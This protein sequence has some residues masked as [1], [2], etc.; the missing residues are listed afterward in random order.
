MKYK[1]LKSI[2]ASQKDP[3]TLQGSSDSF[4][5]KSTRVAPYIEPDFSKVAFPKEKPSILLVSAVGAS[6]KTTAAHALSFDMQLP[7]LDLAKHKAVGDNTLTGILTTSYPIDK[8]G[9]VLE[10][11]QKGTHGIIIDGIDEGR[12]KTTEQA[13]EAF[14]DDLIQLSKGS[15][16]TAIVVFGRSQILLSTW[17]YLADNGAE[18]GMV[19]IDPFTLEQAKEYI[20]SSVTGASIGQQETYE[21]VRNEVLAKL[22]AAFSP[23]TPKDKKD[24]NVFLS[25]IGYPPVLDAIATLLEKERNYHRIHQTLS[26]G[27]EGGLE[28]GLLIRISDYLLDRE[29]KEKA[30]PNFIEQIA[31]T[32]GG[33]L[34]QN[35]RKSLYSREEQCARVLSRALN[36]PF[37]RRVIND[38]A[39]HEQYENA[40]GEW[41]KEH[42]FLDDKSVRNVVFAAFAVTRCTLSTVSEYRDL[43]RDYAVANRPT[44]HLL[45]ILAELAKGH[46]IDARCFN[47]LIQSCSEF[48][49][50]NAD[51]MVDIDGNSWEESG[52][53]ADTSAELTIEI[54]FPEKRQ[55]RTFVLTGT[56]VTNPFRLGRILSTRA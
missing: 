36:R 15:T 22:S 34:G 21:Q 24:K 40:A 35:L 5:V 41:C 44:Y 9:T 2:V 46:D 25:F 11:L 53:N 45:Y 14:L 47:M 28:T 18:V 4:F 27:E 55:E 43:A 16:S 1:I 6:G 23:S 33:P 17:V 49:G 30:L 8:V 37:T 32:V 12:A 10:G 19:Q 31:D 52:G 7:I 50:I 48:M 51:I 13:F 42:P 56:S 3:T 29:H 20:D 54:K 39:L 26:G 38:N